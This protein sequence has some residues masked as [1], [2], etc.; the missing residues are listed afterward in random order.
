MAIL[1]AFLDKATHRDPEQRFASVADAL[2]ALRAVA[3]SRAHERETEEQTTR[4]GH[5]RRSRCRQQVRKQ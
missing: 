2:A 4:C 5:S 3:A 1:A